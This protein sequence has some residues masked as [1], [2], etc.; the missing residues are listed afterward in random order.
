VLSA[1][2]GASPIDDA[3]AAHPIDT[4][5]RFELTGVPP[6][7]ESIEVLP[8]QAQLGGWAGSVTVQALDLG[9]A[10]NASPDEVQIDAG[11]ARL[12]TVTGTVAAEGADV[13]P[14]R[15][16]VVASEHS[17]LRGKEPEPFRQPIG[18]R[19]PV[20]RGGRFAL[21]LPSGQWLLT[22]RD[23]ETGIEL[24][25]S[26]MLRLEPGGARSCD[27]DVRCAVLR[28]RLAPEP[29]FA[30]QAFAVIAG[31]DVGSDQTA[32][33]WPLIRVADGLR[34]RTLLVPPGP[35]EL[36]LWAVDVG[37][38]RSPFSAWTE[39]VEPDTRRRVRA[40]MGE[41]VEVELQP[42]R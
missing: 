16:W 35:V 24:G 8:R 25:R 12:S 22:V 28:L 15:L 30:G 26:E 2:E 39:L 1:W 40:R 42:P 37:A 36:Q 34:T 33:D 27:I 10:G 18:P 17:V 7:E 41:V 21:L 4:E 19:A 3:A 11:P 29:A 9:P 31:A 38:G 20:D 13:T 5:G 14:G 32:L 23:A 6:F